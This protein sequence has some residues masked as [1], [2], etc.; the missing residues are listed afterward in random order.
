VARTIFNT[1]TTLPLI[2]ITLRTLR[3]TVSDGNQLLVQTATT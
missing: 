2:A 1:A 3:R